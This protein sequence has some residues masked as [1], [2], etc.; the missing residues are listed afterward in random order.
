M[1]DL[2]ISGQPR[3]PSFYVW[4][5]T[6]VLQ[7]VQVHDF[8]KLVYRETAGDVQSFFLLVL[9]RVGLFP[10]YDAIVKLVLG[11]VEVTVRDY[12]RDR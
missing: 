10:S 6:V 11:V 1:I 2:A 3:Q 5:G 12:E 8:V 4:L 7:Q 9:G